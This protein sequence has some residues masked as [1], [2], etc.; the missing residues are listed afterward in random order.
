M[1]QR[2]SYCVPSVGEIIETEHGQARV[3]RI[4]SHQEVTEE[5]RASGLPDEEISRLDSRIGRFLGD[6]SR[7]FECEV[8][9]P[10]GETERID[11]SE[12]G[13]LRGRPK[14]ISR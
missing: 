6:I 14:K 9:Y 5:L 2:F 12:Y 11:W 1:I 8:A 4:I 10:N 13:S 7:Y 3:L